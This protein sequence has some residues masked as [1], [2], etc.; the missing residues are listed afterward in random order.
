MSDTTEVGPGIGHNKLSAIDLAAEIVMN[1]EAFI[2]ECPEITDAATANEAQ[3]YVDQLRTSKKDLA[4]ALKVDLVPHEAAIADVKATY[5]SPLDDIEKALKTLLAR[6]AAW[7]LK[8]RDR[9]AAE[10]A[11]KEAEARRLRDEADRLERERQEAARTIATDTAEAD[12][13]AKAA[14]EAAEA[15]RTAKAAERVA[16]RK[17]QTAAI[18]GTTAA[19]AMT[20]RTYWSAVVTDEAAAIESYR[21][22]PVVRKAALAAALQVA[23]EAARTSKDEAAA[24]AGFCF[25]K[26][27]RAS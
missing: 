8:E 16:D 26:E 3:A 5:R 6:S 2:I 10:K 14:A 1:A 23:N 25:V 27:E 18:K 19:R 9:I 13:T 12:A 17:P 20:L 21:D 4:G 7:L 11:A 15:A 24:P 22:H